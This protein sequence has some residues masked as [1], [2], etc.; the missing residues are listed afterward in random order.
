MSNHT[1]TLYT[2]LLAI[3]L[4]APAAIAQGNRAS[5]TTVP[6]ACCVVVS[7]DAA[8][9]IATAK[10]NANGNIFQFKASRPGSAATLAP[11]QPVYANFA[12]HQVSLDGR[13]ACCVMTNAPQAAIASLPPATAAGASNNPASQPLANPGAARTAGPR[14]N[15]LPSI[16]YGA[17]QPINGRTFVRRPTEVV[18]SRQ[19]SAHFGGREATGKIVRL[20]GLSGIEQSTDLPEGAKRLMEIHVR[21]L[22]PNQPHDYIVNTELAQQWMLA[23][24]VPADIKPSD[25]GSHRQHCSGADYVTKANCDYQAA[26]DAVKAV[27]DEAKKDWNHASDELTHD[28]SMATGCFAD[29]TLSLP[30]IPIKFSIAPSLTIPLSAVASGAGI[31]LGASNSAASAK[32]DGSVGLGFPL[33]GDFVGQLDLFYIPCLPF[34]IRPKSIGANGTMTV[35]ETLTA[36]VS[37][38][39]KFDKTF[40]IPPTGGPKIPIEMIPIVIAGVPVAELDVSA[41]IEGNVEVGGNGKAEGHFTL[42]DPHKARLS[43]SCDGSG[44]PS[45]VSQVADPATVSESAEI[46]GQVFV[47]PSVY[48]ALQLDFD[49]D[50]LSARV[51]P[52]PYLL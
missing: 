34:V 18:E 42:S 24:P 2:S 14:A 25:G 28:W 50:L 31:K 44:C 45:A 6:R 16:T 20:R 23:H 15:Q 7:I 22:D 52:Q 47:K 49:F 51:G 46:K 19:I 8:T 32:V 11:G 43:F 30:D 17:P 13:T 9:G 40:K 26:G 4:V 48:T 5:S 1:R 35:G 33:E 21:T 29:E 27:Q 39:G 12:N 36:N 37:A 3:F 38:T 10:V 41:Y